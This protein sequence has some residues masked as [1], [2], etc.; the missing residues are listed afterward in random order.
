MVK[1]WTNSFISALF[2]ELLAK[3]KL[4]EINNK[5]ILEKLFFYGKF[6]M[7]KN[8]RFTVFI[9]LCNSSSIVFRFCY[10]ISAKRKRCDPLT[11]FQLKL[12]LL[13]VYWV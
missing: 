11:V 4:L 12:Y 8:K 6:N 2:V 1:L 9:L 3:K 13:P 7:E 5:F 10:V